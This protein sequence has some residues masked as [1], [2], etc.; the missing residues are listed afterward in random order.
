MA[1][2]LD[3]VGELFESVVAFLVMILLGIVSFYFTVFVVKTGS[4][5][6]GYAPDGNFVVLSAA[7][8][9]VATILGSSYK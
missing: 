5:L 7:L 2:F 8:I 3:A 4:E 9:V 6:A 1:R